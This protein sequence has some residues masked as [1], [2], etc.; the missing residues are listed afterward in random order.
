MQDF[1]GGGGPTLNF[2]G[3]RVGMSRAVAMGVWGH[4]PPRKFLK[5]CNFGPFEGYFQPLS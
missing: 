2:F 4:V 3:L 1:S 5:W